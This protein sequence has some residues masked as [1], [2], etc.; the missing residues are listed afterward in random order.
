MGITLVW[1]AYFTGNLLSSHGATI[2]MMPPRPD[3]PV[4]LLLH[5]LTYI[6]VSISYT[7]PYIIH[8]FSIY[9]HHAS[10]TGSTGHTPPPMPLISYIYIRYIIHISSTHNLS[11]YHDYAPQTPPQTPLQCNVL[12][13]PGFSFADSCL[14]GH[15]TRRKSLFA[16]TKIP[17]WPK[18]PFFDP[19][20]GS[21]FFIK[22][23][24]LT[25]I[26]SFDQRSC[27]DQKSWIL[28]RV[29]KFYCSTALLDSINKIDLTDRGLV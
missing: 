16:V 20:K 1:E 8:I 4:T 25:K 22:N 21:I 17:I 9:Y 14:L 7:Y 23:P 19:H 24:F 11:I 6:H 10:Q 12:S 2:I 3:Q 15:Q 26:K 29:L 18:S 27:F 28:V 13:L 5:S